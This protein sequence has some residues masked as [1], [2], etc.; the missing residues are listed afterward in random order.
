[1]GE[2]VRGGELEVDEN[3]R[4]FFRIFTPFEW[5]FLAPF[6]TPFE[7]FLFK[8]FPFNE[9][10]FKEIPFVASKGILNWICIFFCFRT[11]SRSLCFSINV[12]LRPVHELLKL[13][14]NS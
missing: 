10:P 7:K 13:D 14:Q 6:F 11:N 5:P 4:L 9:F 3:D 12:K 8:E 1:V 2:E